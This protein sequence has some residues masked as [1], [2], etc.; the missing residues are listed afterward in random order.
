MFLKHCLHIRVQY[1]CTHF[2]DI[3]VV[4][5]I[6]V[7][8]LDVNSYSVH[9]YVLHI[10]FEHLYES[11]FQ[12]TFSKETNELRCMFKSSFSTQSVWKLVFNS[13]SP[14]LKAEREHFLM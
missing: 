5:T 4:V 7:N 10:G 13:D 12:F 2:D 9:M 6:L 1:V 3:H 11:L 8:T 14:L